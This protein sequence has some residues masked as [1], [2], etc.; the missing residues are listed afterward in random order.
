MKA[1]LLTKFCE[2]EVLEACDAVVPRIA[3]RLPV[4][5]SAHAH[6]LLETRAASGR[7]VLT[8]RS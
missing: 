2:P 7:V 4:A 3:E 6:E 1:T 8:H 5:D